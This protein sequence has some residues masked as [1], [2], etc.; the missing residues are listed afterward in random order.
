MPNKGYLTRSA[1]A[2]GTA[3][4]AGYPRCWTDVAKRRRGVAQ[5]TNRRVAGLLIA[6]ASVCWLLGCQQVSKGGGLL[7]LRSTENQYS[8]TKLAGRT[9]QCKSDEVAA[10]GFWRDLA[11]GRVKQSASV[12]KQSSITI[13]RIALKGQV[14]EVTAFTGATETVEEPQIFTIEETTGGLLLIYRDRAPGESPQII[15]IDPGNGSFVYSSQH[16]KPNPKQGQRLSRFMHA[17]PVG[18]R[19]PTT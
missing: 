18:R 6:I 9:F 17:L 1:P 7:P 4:L 11:S 14:A 13:W 10:A 19:R 2:T 12:A 3:A 15:T 8:G 16:V 5:D